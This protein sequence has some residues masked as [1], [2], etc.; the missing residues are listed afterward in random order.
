MYTM[1]LRRYG[2]DEP[3]VAQYFAG[4]R[5]PIMP[6]WIMMIVNK[7]IRIIKGVPSRTNV[8]NLDVKQSVERL[9][10]CNGGLYLYKY[11]NGLPPHVFDTSF[12]QVADVHEYN[13]RNALMQ[14]ICQFSSNK[15]KGKISD[16]GA[17]IWHHILNNINPKSAIDSLKKSIQNLFLLSNDIFTWFRTRWCIIAPLQTSEYN[18]MAMCTNI[19]MYFKVYAGSLTCKDSALLHRFCLFCTPKMLWLVYLVLGHIQVPFARFILFIRVIYINSFVSLL[20]MNFILL[21]NKEY[22]IIC[23]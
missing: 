8:D 15:S 20:M 2:R 19:K 4:R 23:P 6:L 17:N 3:H 7:I 5:E 13:T 16:C 1:R 21:C 22:F 11:S 12:S 9:Y 18:C 10:S 14:H